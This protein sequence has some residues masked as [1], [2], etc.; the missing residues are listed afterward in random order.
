[1]RSLITYPFDKKLKAVN[2]TPFEQ[3][4]SPLYNEKYV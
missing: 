4:L 3:K 2:L 1:M